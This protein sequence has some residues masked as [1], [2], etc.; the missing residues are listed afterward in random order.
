MPNIPSASTKNSAAIERIAMGDSKAAENDC[1][2]SDAASPSEPNAE[3][4]PSTYDASSAERRPFER[5]ERPP[6]ITL[7]VIGMIGSTQGV[8]A[9]RSPTR[10]MGP[11]KRMPHWFH[12]SWTKLV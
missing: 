10:K 5:S 7:T 3:D 6:P 1:P 11:R 2:P 12:R 4:R 8:K 9:N